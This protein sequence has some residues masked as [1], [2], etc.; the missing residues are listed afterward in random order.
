M[1][2]LE[3]LEARVT[4]ATFLVSNTSSADIPGSLTR[5]ILNANNSVGMDTIQFDP[6]V[7]GPGLNEAIVLTN[8]LPLLTDHVRILGPDSVRLSIQR[9]DSAPDFRI[10]QIAPG[11][12]VEI[13][14]LRLANGRADLGAGILN[15]GL[16]LLQNSVLEWNQS[17]SAGGQGGAIASFQSLTL[18]DTLIANNSAGVNGTGGGVLVG[19]DSQFS[20]FSSTFTGNTAA[21]GSALF[22]QGSNVSSLL[23]NTT[24]SGNQATDPNGLG[25]AIFV[26]TFFGEFFLDL[27]STTIANNQ[28]A[29]GGIGGIINFGEASTTSSIVYQNTL[30]ADN[31]GANLFEAPG[32]YFGSLMSLGH[33]LSTDNTGNLTASGDQPN[34]PALLRPLGN[35][36]GPVPTHALLP[37]S[38]AIDAGPVLIDVLLDARGFPRSLISDI[39]AFEANYTF[40]MFSGNAHSIAAG[41]VADTQ[42]IVQLLES[43]QP[44]TGVPVAF[45][46]PLGVSFNGVSTVIVPVDALGL[47]KAPFLTADTTPG[48]FSVLASEGANTLTFSVLVTPGQLAGYEVIPELSQVLPG[49]PFFI[50]VKPVDAFGNPFPLDSG[51]LSFTSSDPLA[52]L[53]DPYTF[54]TNQD[55]GNPPGVYRIT[56]FALHTFGNKKITLTPIDTQLG[57]LPVVVS[58]RVLNT[59]APSPSIGEDTTIMIGQPLI[60]SGKILDREDKTFSVTVDYGD[61]SPSSPLEVMGDG[62]IQLFHLYAEPGTYTVV[63]TVVDDQARVRSASFDVKV[64]PIG[65]PALILS[66]RDEFSNVGSVF[67]RTGKVVNAN[68]AQAVV[69]VDYGDGT[70][71]QAALDENGFFQLRHVYQIEGSFITRVRLIVDGVVFDRLAFYV[72]VLLAGVPKETAVKVRIPAGETGIAAVPG[73]TVIYDNNGSTFSAIIVAIVPLHVVDQL[74]KQF[75][76]SRNLT[77]FASYDV[78]AINVS[79]NDV[80]LVTFSFPDVPNRIGDPVLTFFNRPTGKQEFVRSQ[81]FII[82]TVNRTITFILDRQSIPRLTQLTGTVFTIAAPLSTTV[83]TNFSSSSGVNSL[84]LALTGAVQASLLLTESEDTMLAETTRTSVDSGVFVRQL[85]GGHKPD[86]LASLAIFAER[87][88]VELESREGGVLRELPEVPPVLTDLPSVTVTPAGAEPLSPPPASKPVAPSPGQEEPATE[89]STEAE[90]PHQAASASETDLVELNKTDFE[91]RFRRQ[92]CSDALFMVA[93]VPVL[94]ACS[95]SSKRDGDDLLIVAG[96]HSS[97]SESGMGPDDF[98]G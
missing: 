7:F 16:L 22:I 42:L 83:P 56:G 66:R 12:T 37:N 20:S 58:L 13:S 95:R 33:N 60:R 47:A 19:F 44:A 43:G 97:L 77:I 9:A 53:P 32:S 87:S 96:K 91:D 29:P 2:R 71:E 82:D 45:N 51:G 1:L 72:D 69:L 81:L 38:P 5:A 86:A 61:G 89:L 4:P 76:H 67:Q 23:Q 25:G 30:F 88:E 11:L 80:A 28:A 46:A 36:G 27:R 15:Q 92:S 24:I 74:D 78:R 57:V 50:D 90:L 34:T 79:L 98:A 64:T 68:F 54:S 63:V 73:A 14:N 75:F 94:V 55:L 35:Y 3:I 49:Q 65:Q 8:P 10:F 26:H 85:L 93:L 52:V 21:L 40:E 48:Q 17:L 70:R 18:V 59:N 31:V 41:T 6:S 39:G 84:S 62:S